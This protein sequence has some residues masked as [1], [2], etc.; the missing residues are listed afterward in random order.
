MTTT[1][2][3]GS[4]TMEESLAALVRAGRLERPTAALRAAHPDELD[5]LLAGGSAPRT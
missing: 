5:L 2:R 3:L 1:R 4:F